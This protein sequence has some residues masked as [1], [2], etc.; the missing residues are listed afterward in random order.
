MV[1][2]TAWDAGE[3]LTEFETLVNNSTHIKKYE[4][5]EIVAD[6]RQ[7]LSSHYLQL[8][9]RAV[10]MVKHTGTANHARVP[11]AALALLTH[12]PA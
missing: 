2:Y 8:E 5:S 7:S 12:R 1:K 10:R 11:R 3:R 9:G 6:I 4:V